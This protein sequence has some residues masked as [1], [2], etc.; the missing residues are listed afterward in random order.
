MRVSLASVWFGEDG[1]LW[2]AL[3]IRRYGLP[4][5]M[6]IT[7]TRWNGHIDSRLGLRPSRVGRLSGIPGSNRDLGWWWA[8]W[9]PRLRCTLMIEFLMDMDLTA[10][11]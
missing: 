8:D 4:M 6:D 3:L 7:V 2:W 9:F 1:R 11:R 10:A 5:D